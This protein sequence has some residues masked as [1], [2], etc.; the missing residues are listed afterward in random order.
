MWED[1]S[2][3]GHALKQI[4]GMYQRCVAG[5]AAATN[6]AVADVKPGDA[7]VTVTMFAGGVP[8][9]VTAEATITSAGNIQLSTTNS[10]GN[11]LQV[12]IAPKA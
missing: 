8:S 10:T 1:I 7:I 9:D 5:A 11:T 4:Q 12:V 3:I 2:H 6:I